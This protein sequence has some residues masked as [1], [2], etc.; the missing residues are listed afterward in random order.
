[1]THQP[2]AFYSGAELTAL[3]ALVLQR[4][5]TLG[6][7]RLVCVD[8]PAGSGKTTLAAE[9]QQLLTRQTPAVDVLH[10]DDFY[11]GW[12]GIDRA[13]R[14]E[15]RVLDQV[16]QPLAAGRP[17]RWQ[18]YDWAAGQFAEW[19]E[20]PVPE[21]LIMEG[22]ASG[23]LAYAAYVTVLAWVEADPATRTARGVERDGEAVL[24]LWLRWMDSEAR[25]FAANRTRAR[26]DV[27]LSTG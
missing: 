17:G 24:A 12:S 5:P 26:A 23:A 7:S 20:L 11:E 15:P 4:P 16:L 9:L 14:L 10:L 25:H 3:A 22:C 1:M 19:L 2:E 8:G 13:S 21:V 18:R 27:L 6:R